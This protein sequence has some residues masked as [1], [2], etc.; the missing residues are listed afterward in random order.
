MVQ[1]V[2]KFLLVVVY[3]DVKGIFC[4]VFSGFFSHKILQKYY[5]H[6]YK[7]DP[8]NTCGCGTAGGFGFCTQAYCGDQSLFPNQCTSCDAGYVPNTD[9]SA[10]VEETVCCQQLNSPEEVMRACG[11]EGCQCCPD[12]TWSGSIGDGRTFCGGLILGQD[13]FGTVC[14]GNTESLV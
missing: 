6:S 7:P 13:Q 12:G 14:G 5:L 9:G 3:K 11:F 4:V 10:C 1:Y 2:K 8:C